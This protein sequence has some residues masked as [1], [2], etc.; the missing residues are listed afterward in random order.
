MILASGARGPGFKSRTSPAFRF[1]RSQTERPKVIL[2]WKGTEAGLERDPSELS[3]SKC[4]G[5]SFVLS[6]HSGVRKGLTVH[7]PQCPGKR[8]GASE[9]GQAL[10]F[11]SPTYCLVPP[12]DRQS[13][14]AV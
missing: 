4:A 14:V 6:R 12:L 5:S 1:C 2:T 9:L 7:S 10:A 3:A 8:E 13:L 11:C